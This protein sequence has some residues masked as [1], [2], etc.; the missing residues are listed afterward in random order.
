M[1]S[2]RNLDVVESY[3]P[4]F[5]LSGNSASKEAIAAW[6]RTGSLLSQK[7]ETS[8]YT[9]TKLQSALPLIRELTLEKNPN[10]F[11]KK[12]KTLLAGSGVALVVIP[13]YPKTY[14]TGATFWEHK[15]KAVIMMSLRG[16]WGDVFWFSLFHEIGHI[17]LHGKRSV[18][19]EGKT[20][21]EEH[22]D[23][24]NEADKF[25]SDN[26]IPINQYSKFT[27]ECVFT[28][29]SIECFSA[30]IGIHPGIITGRLQHESLLPYT[31]HPCRVR[32]KWEKPTLTN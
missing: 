3:N 23:Q 18:F 8:K 5:R 1:S 27:A 25:A 7:I 19:I 26:L 17:L 29:K 6:L 9:K 16:S 30:E 20:I 14:V 22:K 21:N 24:E 13:H 32:Y 11:L 2:L 31:K 10:I 15:K 12:L 4:A 28:Q